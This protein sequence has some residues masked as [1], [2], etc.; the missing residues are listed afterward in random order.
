MHTETIQLTE[1]SVNLGAVPITFCCGF[2][3]FLALVMFWMKDDDK[4]GIKTDP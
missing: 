3:L 4:K 1:L 2:V